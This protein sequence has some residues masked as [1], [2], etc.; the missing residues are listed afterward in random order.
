M[1]RRQRAQHFRERG[2]EPAVAASPKMRADIGVIKKSVRLLQLVEIR[3]EFS[4]DAVGVFRVMRGA[5]RLN[6]QTADHET[7]VHPPARLFAQAVG[8]RIEPL[9]VGHAFAKIEVTLVAAE[10]INFQ[11]QNA[12]DVK[13]QMAIG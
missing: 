9:V 2:G 5:I 1:F 10:E 6:L 11:R 8:T 7:V 12:E 13:I 3:G 4:R